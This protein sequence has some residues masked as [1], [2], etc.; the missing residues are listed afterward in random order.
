MGQLLT[1]G[2]ILTL[3]CNLVVLPALI[4]L[5]QPRGAELPAPE[6]PPGTS[7]EPGD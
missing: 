6:P 4:P 7:A 2:V 5:R 1:V 3:L